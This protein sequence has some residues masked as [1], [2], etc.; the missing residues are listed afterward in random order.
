MFRELRSR[1]GAVWCTLVHESLMWPAH[2]HYGCRT[3][4]RRY[5]AFAASKVNRAER[6]ICKLL[7]KG[8]GATRRR[9]VPIQVLFGSNKLLPINRRFR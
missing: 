4:G 8:R 9:E 5:P 3:C 2:G 1:I 6:D 7:N